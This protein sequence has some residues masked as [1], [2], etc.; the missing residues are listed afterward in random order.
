[1]SLRHPVQGQWLGK[2]G[3]GGEDKE[4]EGGEDRDLEPTLQVFLELT[5]LLRVMVLQRDQG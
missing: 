2:G 3:E 1:M 4:G 5:R